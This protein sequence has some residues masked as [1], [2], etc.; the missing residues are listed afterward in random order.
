MDGATRR[1]AGR[2][3][4]ALGIAAG[5]SLTGV[6]ATTTASA[7]PARY[8]AA[9]QWGNSQTWETVELG[10]GES[11]TLT[12]GLGDFELY[13]QPGSEGDR[14]ILNITLRLG[15]D[16]TYYATWGASVSGAVEINGNR[17]GW[18]YNKAARAAD[19]AFH[20]TV[21]KYQN[22]WDAPWT[23][24]RLHAGDVVDIAYTAL[25]PNIDRSTTQAN[26]RTTVYIR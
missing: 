23:N 18:T 8:V 25:I 19:Y 9:A 10:T 12:S 5:L 13:V 6:V 3:L 22:E 7:A 2:A 24:H 14:R 17:T 16:A 20:S 11:A 15:P 21:N 4:L 1:R 26:Y